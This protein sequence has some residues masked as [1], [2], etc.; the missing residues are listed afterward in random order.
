MSAFN[1]HVVHTHLPYSNHGRVKVD[2]MDTGLVIGR[3]FRAY[4][5]VIKASATVWYIRFNTPIPVY[6]QAVNVECDSGGMRVAAVGGSVQTGA[7]TTLTSIGRNRSPSRPGYPLDADVPYVPQ[8]VV[9]WAVAG[10]GIV[11]G[12]AE[13]NVRRVRTG[14]S[15]G[16]NSSNSSQSVTLLQILGAGDYIIKI[17]PLTGVV[18]GDAVNGIVTLA[19]EEMPNGFI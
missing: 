19:W 13:T 12:G 9:S 6:L 14:L 8:A 1:Q 5:E 11:T 7:W 4:L 15:T 3:Q 17:E 18:N 16:N 10:T 2:E